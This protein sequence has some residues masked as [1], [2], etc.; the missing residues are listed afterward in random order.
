M[1]NFLSYVIVISLIKAVKTL[2]IHT[3]KMLNTALGSCQS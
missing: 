3:K 2:M 1:H